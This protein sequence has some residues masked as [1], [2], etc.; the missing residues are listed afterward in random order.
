MKKRLNY[1]LIFMF[2]CFFSIVNVNA[3]DYR[4]EYGTGLGDKWES[5]IVLHINVDKTNKKAGFTLMQNESAIFK[6]INKDI[7]IEKWNE[8]DGGFTAS[9]WLTNGSIHSGYALHTKIYNDTFLEKL[10]QLET[11]GASEE[12]LRQH[13]CLNLVIGAFTNERNVSILTSTGEQKW[14]WNA[15]VKKVTSIALHSDQLTIDDT[16]DN[17]WKD[18][19]FGTY[20]LKDEIKYYE[21]AAKDLDPEILNSDCATFS[22]YLSSLQQAVNSGGCDANATFDKRYTEIIDLCNSF[23][24]TA[25]Y[26]Q[27]NSTG[28]TVA[29]SC[30]KACTKLYV[31]VD[32]M[33]G[34]SPS[35]ASCGSLGHK[36]VSWLFKIIKFVRYAIPALLII[37][38]ILDYLK[39]IAADSEDEMK[40]VV[41]RF[42]KRLIAAALIFIIPFLLE[43]ILN[44]FNLPG[45]NADNIFCAK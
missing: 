26:A 33:C 16:L 9:K 8:V 4:C 38:S 17:D 41:S 12:E 13:Y 6:D 43:F 36:L 34:K 28:E 22:I 24:Q 32:K 19:W 1:F 31:Q 44:I 5:K 15:S 40:K 42:S 23:R 20:E 3:V 39:A 37:L 45:L 25:H 29:K 21:K 30:S 27:V 14:G 10:I 35:N 18:A 2:L 7:P 11:P